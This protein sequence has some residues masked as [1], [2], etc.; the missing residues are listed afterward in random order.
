MDMLLAVVAGSAVVLAGIYWRHSHGSAPSSP[1]AVKDLNTLIAWEPQATRVLT[2]SER[3]AYMALVRALPEYMVLAQVPLARFIRVPTRHSYSEWLRRVGQL[4]PDLLICDASSQVVAV[5]EVR[6]PEEQASPR[7]QR[8]LERMSRVLKGAGIPL[9]IWPENALP[10][11]EAAR[12]AILRLLDVPAEP[13][14]KP[15]ALD[16]V[17]KSAAVPAAAAAATAAVAVAKG[18]ATPI[19]QPLDLELVPDEVIEMHEPPP[20]TWFDDLDSGPTPLKV[21]ATLETVR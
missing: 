11:P 7:A 13:V 3:R 18:A 8:R 20:S 21:D 16:A 5:V 10:S 4:C 15:A 9:S 19:V 2:A 12:E 14:S 17:R 1:R 6:P